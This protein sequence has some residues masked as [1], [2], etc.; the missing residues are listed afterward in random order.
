M[1]VLV[2][3]HGRPPKSGA[4]STGGAFR[5]WIHAEALRGAGHDVHLL[6]RAQDGPSGFRSPADLRRLAAA[7]APDWILCVAPEEAPA[8]AKVAPLVVDLYAPRLLEAAWEGLQHEEAGRALRAVA[9]ADEVLFSNPRQRWFWMGLLGACGWDLSAPAGLLVP[10]AVVPGPARALPKKPRFVVGGHPWPWQDPSATLARAVTHLGRRGEVVSFGLPEVQGVRAHPAVPRE[11]W[12]L[13][14]AGAT[15]ALDRYA[16][17]PERQ[18]AM[19][20]RQ[21]DYLACGLPLITDADSPLADEVRATRAG[22]VDEPLEEA[23][24]DAIAHPRDAAALAARFHPRVTEAPLLAWVPQR[25]ARAWNLFGA[26]ARLARAEARASSAETLREA[27]ETEVAV[28]REE[29]VRLDA[30]I[31]AL[32]SSVEA[33]SAAVA[34]VAGFRREAVAALGTRLAGREA[35]GEQLRRE[36]EITRAELEKKS[37]ELAAMQADRDRNGKAMQFLRGK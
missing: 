7:I 28:K 1:R 27:A 36:L 31:R 10:L 21:A 24:D 8:L 34:D 14:C 2:V 12:L 25:R 33:A 20:F 19:S 3:H 4:P 29:I 5:A 26:G 23:L 17:N 30:Q 22:W 15:A 35:E 37:L 6:T 11:D 18:L 16:P 13:A 32:V 9:A